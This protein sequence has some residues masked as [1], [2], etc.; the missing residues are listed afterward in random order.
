[1]FLKDDYGYCDEIFIYYLDRTPGGRLQ[2]DDIWIERA[3]EDRLNHVGEIRV[4]E[5]SQFTYLNMS[6][7]VRVMHDYVIISW[8]VILRSTQLL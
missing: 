1:M 3:F 6:T 5:I 7:L 4:A 2:L 8:F